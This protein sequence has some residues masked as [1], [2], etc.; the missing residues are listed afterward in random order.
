LGRGDQAI[1][2]QRFDSEE[3]K[4]EPATGKRRNP[5]KKLTKLKKLGKKGA[6]M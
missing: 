3:K 6:L 5:T 2:K 1:I 4:K